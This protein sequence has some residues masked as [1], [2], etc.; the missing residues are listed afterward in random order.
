M[1]EKH[2]DLNRDVI[3]A[4]G[5]WSWSG[6]LPEN[7]YAF[8]MTK[9]ALDACKKYGIK[10]MMTTLWSFEPEFSHL[11]GLSFTAEMAYTDCLER[12]YLKSRFEVCTKGDYD[13]F[14]AM[15]AYHNDF[16]NGKEY[17][18]YGDRF[19]GPPLFYQD[20]FEGKADVIAYELQLSGHY[21]KYADIMST[22]HGEWEELYRWCEALLR[23]LHVRC[24]IAENIKPAYDKGDRE[25]L[26]RIANELLPELRKCTIE[27]HNIQKKRWLKLFKGHRERDLDM[28]YGYI[29]SRTITCA[30]RLNEYLEG[31][32]DKIDA[33][34]EE[35]LPYKLTGFA[36]YP[37]IIA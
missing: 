26:Y 2:L 25:M 1:L 12:E 19:A 32:T 9:D 29:I 22:Y 31:K 30:E 35:R 23:F 3:F 37:R 11:L 14:W 21:K 15:S 18:I 36:K 24:L 33:L 16:D 17:E 34:A 8:D 13:A 6:H 7:H 20:I 10:E 4:G 27:V 5:L 28:K